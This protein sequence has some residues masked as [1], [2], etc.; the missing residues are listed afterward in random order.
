LIF[1]LSFYILYLV[2]GVKLWQYFTNELKDVILVL[3]LI[4][5]AEAILSG[6]QFMAI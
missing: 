2:K 6:G 4:L 5:A 3:K 1:S